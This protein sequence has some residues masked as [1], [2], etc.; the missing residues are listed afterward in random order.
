MRL[1]HSATAAFLSRLADVLVSV[2][3]T[4][5]AK[6]GAKIMADKI[7][8]FIRL[9]PYTYKNTRKHKAKLL[10]WFILPWTFY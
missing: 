5:P 3:D 6:R 4:Q 10:T 8:F 7:A 2:V 9:F 1:V